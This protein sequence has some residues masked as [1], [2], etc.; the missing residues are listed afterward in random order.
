[1]TYHRFGAKLRWH[2]R[3]VGDPP[4]RSTKVKELWGV[5][6]IT[7]HLEMLLDGA[8][9]IHR[10]DCDVIQTGR[11]PF[12][13]VGDIEGSWEGRTGIFESHAYMPRIGAAVWDNGLDVGMYSNYLNHQRRSGLPFYVI[14]AW[15]ATDD[16]Y[17]GVPETFGS[18]LLGPGIRILGKRVDQLGRY[19][20]A[21]PGKEYWP[22]SELW[23]LEK[24]AEDFRNWSGFPRQEALL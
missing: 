3:V 5:S 10:G 20:A 17:P 2:P 9:L 23:T 18:E 15:W 11:P 22:L 7:S 14:W 6:V 19:H 1:M 16:L 8:Q 13:I 4:S 21:S 12:K 24:I